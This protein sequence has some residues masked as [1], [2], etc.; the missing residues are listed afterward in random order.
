MHSAGRD[1]SGASFTLTCIARAP[2]MRKAMPIAA[3]WT[4]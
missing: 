2:A 3:G 1:L 4:S